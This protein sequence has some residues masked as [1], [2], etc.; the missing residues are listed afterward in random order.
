MNSAKPPKEIKEVLNKLRPAVIEYVHYK[1]PTI[2]KID[3]LRT[4]KRKVV[5]TVDTDSN[6][7]NL[8][9]WVSFAQNDI[10]KNIKVIRSRELNNPRFIQSRDPNIGK[11]KDIERPQIFRIMYTMINFIDEMIMKT[12]DMTVLNANVPLD[13]PGTTFM[14]NEFLY[15]SLLLMPAKKH[16][17][18]L[19]RIRE[20][21]Y[22]NTPRLDVKGMEYRKSNVA[23]STS[24]FVEKLVKDDILSNYNNLNMKKILRKIS[25]FEDSIVKSVLNG[26]DTYLK[27]V[28]IKGEDA[29]MRDEY[30]G[31]RKIGTT[32]PLSIWQYKAAYIWNYLNPDKKIELPGNAIIVKVNMSKPKDFADMAI[33]Y[34]D[35]Y[36]KLMALFDKDLNKEMRKIDPNCRLL[37]RTGDDVSSG[38]NNIAIPIGEKMPD[39]LKPYINLDE[40]ISNNTTLLL[41]ILN[42]LGVKS[43]NKTKST[44]FFSNIIKL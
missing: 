40:I 23:K 36:N 44:E 10:I 5:T 34:P 15:E 2:N 25:K 21:V 29:Y 13:N 38:I 27:G 1:Y 42:S 37:P 12:L 3:R 24:K 14:K 39:W 4:Q 41:Q 16:Y 35:I 43:I 33:S 32:N 28:K 6:F 7:I 30:D 26:E 31:D 11:K 17:Q 9:N 18:G 20:G 19:I 22:F 8:G